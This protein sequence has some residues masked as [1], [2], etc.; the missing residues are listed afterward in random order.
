MPNKVV[1]PDM[2]NASRSNSVIKNN[3]TFLNNYKTGSHKILDLDILNASG[4]DLVYLKPRTTID[5]DPAYLIWIKG[6]IYEIPV[7]DAFG[8]YWK[9]DS[10]AS[11]ASESGINM[12]DKIGYRLD[13]TTV[14]TEPLLMWAFAND[15]KT[16]FAGFGYTKAPYST[17]FSVANG[18]RDSLA[19][20]GTVTNARSFTIGSTVQILRFI[21]VPYPHHWNFGTIQS[22][23]DNT[24]LVV[25]LAPTLDISNTDI[26]TGIGVIRQIDKFFPWNG[27]T[28]TSDVDDRIYK[29]N[30]RL[31]GQTI[32]DPG[33][34]I[35][36][37]RKSDDHWSRY[38]YA[39]FDNGA[40]KLN[41]VQN[42]A[43]TTIT[44]YPFARILPLWASAI[45][46]NISHLRTQG[47]LEIK[48]DNVYGGSS[49]TEWQLNDTYTP[50]ANQKDQIP[51]LLNQNMKADLV[52]TTTGSPV[53]TSTTLSVM[54]YNDGGL[55]EL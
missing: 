52:I 19:T 1:K 39:F 2:L 26:A 25:Q 22:I 30:Y 10:R 44:T 21:G 20:I 7:Q 36:Y 41:V 11:S 18:A 35:T 17:F 40:V 13:G 4:T 47:T 33:G 6:K 45:M 49:F 54:G 23:P 46:L 55:S 16:E 37:T 32:L 5:K 38:D 9:L 3:Q 42:T 28:D 53:Q 43:T 50:N 27:R 31:V 12:T 24:T 29:P 51:L 8:S 34:E 48:I 14:I 15:A